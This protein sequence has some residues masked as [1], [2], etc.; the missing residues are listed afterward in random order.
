MMSDAAQRPV[1]DMNIFLKDLEA[2]SFNPVHILDVGANYGNW[3]RAA[4]IAFPNA[5][6][7]LVE[8]QIEMKPYL[9]KFCT[10]NS[11][12][13]WVNVGAGPMNE[14]RALTVWP[15]LAGS[16]FIPTETEAKE[17][18][19]KRRVVPIRTIDSILSDSDLPLPDLVKMDIQGFELEALHGAATLLGRTELFILEVAFFKF[20]TDQPTFVAVIEFMSR[21]GYVP[22]DFCGFLRRP[23]DGALGQADVAFAKKE[24]L[25][26]SS[27]RWG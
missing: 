6:F 20:S 1:G 17:Y 7:T 2:R 27:K 22:Y 12:S 23:Y 16:S 14:E 11:G 25:L 10:E 5:A 9:D 8:P 24:G 3:S 21:Q 19:K 18:G 4:K 13:R 15:D 26:R